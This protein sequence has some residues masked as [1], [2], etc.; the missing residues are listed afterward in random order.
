MR[1]SRCTGVCTVTVAVSRR[2]RVRTQPM[3]IGGD[4][5]R[6]RGRV[7]AWTR[8]RSRGSGDTGASSP[9]SDALPGARQVGDPV[10][11]GGPVVLAAVVASR[12][13]RAYAA[14]HHPGHRVGHAAPTPGRWPAG[15]G[16]SR[17]SHPSAAARPPTRKLQLE[18]RRRDTPAAVPHA[19]PPPARS[20]PGRSG[21]S[22]TRTRRPASSGASSTRVPSGSASITSAKRAERRVVPAPTTTR[23]PLVE[24]TPAIAPGNRCRPG[25]RLIAS[26]G[27]HRSRCRARAKQNSP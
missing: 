24:P 27:R 10:Q 17:S 1:R 4:H 15:A 19:S 8:T 14:Q 5:R 22:S 18:A 13:T 25:G 9:R 2:T 11:V 26:R 12:P 7:R 23:M 3:S 20:R 6:H 16:T 21:R